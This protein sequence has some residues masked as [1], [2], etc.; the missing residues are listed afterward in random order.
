MQAALAQQA[1]AGLHGQQPAK[2]VRVDGATGLA[3]KAAAEARQ[4]A[5]NLAEQAAAEAA[6]ALVQEEE[7]AAKAAQRSKQKAAAKK[8]RQKQRKVHTARPPL[9]SAAGAC[10]SPA[11]GKQCSSRQMTGIGMLP[12]PGL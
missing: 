4:A 3:Q 8:A 2:S 7:Q 9:R 1:L 12:G 11:S 10:S 5:A 6:A